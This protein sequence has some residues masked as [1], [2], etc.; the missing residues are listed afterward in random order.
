MWMAI[1]PV[2][3]SLNKINRKTW[4][5][6]GGIVLVLGL[7]GGLYY[8]G[9]H[10]GDTQTRIE[11][12]RVIEDALKADVIV[13]PE[14]FNQTQEVKE[15]AKDVKEVISEA[16]KTSINSVS[17]ARLERVRQQQQARAAK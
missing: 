5:I 10:S 7:L 11:N 1:A 15:E 12:S 4:L 8:A 2:L 16:P 17:R 3:A 6:I 9:K 13:M 14:V